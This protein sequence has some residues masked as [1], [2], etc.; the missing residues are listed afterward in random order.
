MS[1]RERESD[2]AKSHVEYSSLNTNVF[3]PLS[4]Q[5]HLFLLE[6]LESLFVEF[7]CCNDTKKGGGGGGGGLGYLYIKMK[8]LFVAKPPFENKSAQH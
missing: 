6:T 8:V 2:G 1:E 4:A 3:Q 7:C 5:H